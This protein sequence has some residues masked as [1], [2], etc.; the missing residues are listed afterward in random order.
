ML[1]CIENQTGIIYEISWSLQ[2]RGPSRR[3]ASTPAYDVLY[4]WLGSLRGIGIDAA[5]LVSS[6]SVADKPWRQ[7][8]VATILMFSSPFPRYFIIIIFFT[9][10]S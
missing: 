7:L 6:I 10:Y 9:I 8:S 4:T 1:S 2:L 5:P 3:P